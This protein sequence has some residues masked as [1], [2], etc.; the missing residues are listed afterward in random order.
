MYTE[1]PTF[2]NTHAL[3][4]YNP[5][6]ALSIYKNIF[7]FLT[8]GYLL[9]SRHGNQRPSIALS[10]IIIDKYYKCEKSS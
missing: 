2:T 5:F 10:F 8:A 6:L 9:N 1:R 7:F 3:I 4:Q